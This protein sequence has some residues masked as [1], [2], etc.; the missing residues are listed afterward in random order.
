MIYKG[1]LWR[2]GRI[3]SEGRD[4]LNQ[5]VI[6]SELGPPSGRKGYEHL[7]PLGTEVLDQ[8]GWE[9]AHSQGQGTG[10][11][12]AEGIR[13]A[14][15]EVNQKLQK[16]YVEGRLAEIVQE[17][18]PGVRILLTTETATWP[19][20]L[21]LKQIQYTVRLT[22]PG[23]KVATEVFFAWISV[24][25]SMQ[26]AVRHGVEERAGWNQLNRFLAPGSGGGSKRRRRKGGGRP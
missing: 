26:P 16:V 5:I 13:L 14:P 25:D 7:L 12:S 9:R 11:E 18:A 8:K 19:G 10:A 20:T 17:K 24:S 1:R 23:D 4:A 2:Q 6:R 3:I 15:S 21:R 22:R